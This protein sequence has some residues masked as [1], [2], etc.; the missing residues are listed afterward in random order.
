M[1]VRPGDLTFAHCRD[2]V[3]DIVLVSDDQILDA[4]RLL[5]ARGKL[6]V[7]FSGAATLAALIS[8]EVARDRR[9][10]V[11]LSGGNLDP[12]RA[13]SLMQPRQEAVVTA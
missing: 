4:T 9:T 1:P 5:L 10:A 8:G 11:V 6:M 2:L 7:E 12:V 3:D 13:L